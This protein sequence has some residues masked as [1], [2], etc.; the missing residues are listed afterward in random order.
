[1]WIRQE[2][3]GLKFVRYFGLCFVIWVLA[4]NFSCVLSTGTTSPRSRLL[5]LSP[6]PSWLFLVAANIE[7]TWARSALASCDFAIAGRHRVARARDSLTIV[8][9]FSTLCIISL[10]SLVSYSN[11]TGMLYV[12]TIILQLYP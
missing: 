8:S 11:V 6:S 10:M 3:S 12:F 9:H 1:M 2:Q 4:W 5:A 7:Y